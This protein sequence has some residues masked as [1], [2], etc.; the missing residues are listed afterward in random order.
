MTIASFKTMR[1]EVEAAW[2]YLNEM[3]A[4][5][6]GMRFTVC[7]MQQELVMLSGEAI[8]DSTYPACGDTTVPGLI[9]Q[10][11]ASVLN[12]DLE[13]AQRHL[14]SIEGQREPERRRHAHEVGLLEARIASGLG[15][16]DEV[17]ALLERDAIGGPNRAVRELS[18][19]RWLVAEAYE[20]LGQL[21]KAAEMFELVCVPAGWPSYL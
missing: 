17:I 15:R 8:D 6:R 5:R 21:D 12:G 11:T 19:V 18:R 3:E 4:S 13:S 2:H 14:Q 20:R 10:A 1:G 7:T 16:W 9:A